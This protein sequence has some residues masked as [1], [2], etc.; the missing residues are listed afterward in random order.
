MAS[1]VIGVRRGRVQSEAKTLG[2]ESSRCV[3]DARARTLNSPLPQHSPG[4]QALHILL[5]HLFNLP[6]SL[7]LPHPHNVSPQF[8]PQLCRHSHIPANNAL[9]SPHTL[10]INTDSWAR[11]TLNEA[12]VPPFT[13][14]MTSVL[15]LCLCSL[16]TFYV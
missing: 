16:V 2:K 7:H 13:N 6:A 14:R 8:L 4:R 3:A 5:R 10:R 12:P 1:R 9:L 11:R 15:I